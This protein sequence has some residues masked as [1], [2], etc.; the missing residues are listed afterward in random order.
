M[1]TCGG[2]DWIKNG[3][4]WHVERH[5][6][7]G[8]LTVRSMAHGGRVRLPARYVAEHVELLYATTAHRAQGST[9]DTAHPLITAGMARESLYVLASRARERT[10]FYVATHDLPFDEDDRVD[11]TRTSPHAYAAREILLNVLA[12]EATVLSAT[13]TIATAQEEAGSLATLVP[14]YEHAARQ[15][16][17]RRYVGAATGALGDQV[18][19]DLQADP[20]WP[21]VVRRLHGAEASGWD[22]VRLL[23]T[24]AASWELGT[25]GSIA[26]VLAWRLDGHLADGE[27]PPRNGQPYEPAAAA[28]E[29]LADVARTTLGSEKADLAQAEVAW[30]ALIT[31]LR[32]AETTDFDAAELLSHLVDPR[33]VRTAR[34]VSEALAIR[35]NRYLATHP[36]P[37]STTNPLRVPLPWMTPQSSVGSPAVA[38]YLRDAMELINTRVAELADTAVR[39]RPPWMQ[40]L[41]QPPADPERKRQW[42]AH[43]AIVAAYREQF[44]VT[45]DDPGHVLGPHAEPGTPARKPY[46]HAAESILAARRLAGLEASTSATSPDTE[47]RAQAASDIYRALPEKERA[48]ISTEMARKL[49]PLWF[50][51][52]T[53]PDE[54]AASRPVHTAALARTL[55]RHGYLTTGA[56]HAPEPSATG[57]LVE[58]RGVRRSPVRDGRHGGNRVPAPP[59]PVAA[60]LH[61]PP[62]P[63]DAT[64]RQGPQPRII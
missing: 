49:G 25:A 1:S 55:A 9:V 10:T 16:A 63:H 59:G 56:P 45:T 3:D 32:R 57:G 40:P 2:R 5:H 22:P 58:A 37:E 42:L 61:V 51:S 47:A 20:A 11:R 39:H 50:G 54:E 19:A 41:G 33:E 53:T 6:G 18:G 28:R 23:A 8:S 30:P 48:E 62:R 36:D 7:D 34:S 43:V 29:R 14:R 12:T 52:S 21:Q 24:V 64:A 27:A 46:W 60:P 15:H 31:A 44:T 26:E 35:I 13:E 38:Q 17:E 4:S